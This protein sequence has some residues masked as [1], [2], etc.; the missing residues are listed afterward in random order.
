MWLLLHKSRRLGDIRAM[1]TADKVEILPPI[2][3][4]VL[5]LTAEEADALLLVIEDLHIS[6]RGVFPDA[7]ALAAFRRV[8]AALLA[9]RK[10]ER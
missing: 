4:I 2:S 9:A 1:I 7:G 8:K 6:G 3:D 5:K 10:G